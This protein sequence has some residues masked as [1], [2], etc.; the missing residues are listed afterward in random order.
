SLEGTWLYEARHSRSVEK[1]KTITDEKWV[2]AHMYAV[3]PFV[4]RLFECI[5][6][7][8]KPE[9][10]RSSFIDLVCPR[11]KISF[12]LLSCHNKCFRFLSTHSAVINPSPKRKTSKWFHRSSGGRGG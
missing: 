12:Y 7:R 1:T 8:G 11:Q 2:N 6:R 3:R 4:E 9:G 10:G 5:R